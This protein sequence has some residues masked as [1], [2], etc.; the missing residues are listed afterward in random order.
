[1][2]NIIILGHLDT[3]IFNVEFLNYFRKD[4]PGARSGNFL[5]VLI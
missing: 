5:F 1:M 2:L 4:P 3:E